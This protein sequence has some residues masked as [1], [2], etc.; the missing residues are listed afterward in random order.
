MPSRCCIQYASKSG[1]ASSGH[2]TGKGHSSSQF[3]RR[4]VLKN[5]LT[6]RQLHSSPTPGKGVAQSRPSLWDPMDSGPPGSSVNGILQVRTPEWVA[7]PFSRGSSQPRD[8]TW[9][10]HITGRL[11]TVWATR[12]APHASKVMLKILH[13]RLKH[14]ANQELPDVQAGFRKGRR[15]RDQTANICWII[16]KAG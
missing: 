7:I 12:E 4:V 14:Y 11:F 16:E 6:I 13:A 15:T 1:R 2:G 5:V 8:W 3:P 10:F 9:V